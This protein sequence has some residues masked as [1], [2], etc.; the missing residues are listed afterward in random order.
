M[1]QIDGYTPTVNRV[2]VVAIQEQHELSQLDQM[3]RHSIDTEFPERR[4][5]DKK[6][7]FSRG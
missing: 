3:V 2:E 4:I 1:R 7:T 5:D 6:R